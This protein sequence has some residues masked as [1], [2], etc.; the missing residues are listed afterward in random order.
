[1]G[2]GAP[3]LVF[4]SDPFPCLSTREKRHP[5]GGRSPPGVPVFLRRKG[6][7]GGG[8]V[9]NLLLV[10]HFSIRLRRRSCGNVGISPAFGEISKGLWKEGEACLWLSTLSIAPPFP[11]LSFRHGS[12]FRHFLSPTLILQPVFYA[13][14]FCRISTN[15][16]A[17]ASC[18]RR[19][20]AVSLS[21]PASRSKSACVV[22]GRRCHAK[23]GN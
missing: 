15:N 18:I 1:M 5:G 2:G 12:S 22:P 10:F 19:A 20:A 4:A 17:F 23:P 11:Q 21:A 8:K 7:R 16:F 3:H 14:L 9:G 13:L 6:I